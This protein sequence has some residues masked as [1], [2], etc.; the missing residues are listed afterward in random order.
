VT[1]YD[2]EQ[3]DAKLQD[4]YSGDVPVLEFDGG[5]AGRGIQT[6]KLHRMNRGL[7]TALVGVVVLAMLSGMWVWHSQQTNGHSSKNL[8]DGIQ[9]S[10]ISYDMDAVDLAPAVADFGVGL[11]R[12]S[13]RSNQ[14]C[15][16]SPLSAEMALAMTANGAGGQTLEQMMK[17]LA[18]GGDLDQLNTFL[19][20]YV[21]SLP[22]EPSSKFHMANSIWLNDSQ[23]VQVV[24]SFLQANADWFGAGVFSAPFSAQTV[25]DMNDWVAKQTDDMIKDLVKS[26]DPKSDAVVLLNALAFDAKWQQPY[27]DHN[28]TQ[29][30]FTTEDGVGQSAQFLN[31]MEST[32][33]DDGKAT[34]FVK[35]YDGD[36]YRFVALLPNEGVSMP[37]YLASLNWTETMQSAT[38]DSVWAI[39][40]EFSF[41]FSVDMNDALQ[42]MGMTD[43]FTSS[44]DFGQMGTMNGQPLYIGLV[45]Q[46]THIDVTP[47]GTTAGAA[48]EVV[49]MGGSAMVESKIVK[50][51]RPFV[52]AIVDSATELPIFIGVVNSLNG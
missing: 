44:A 5:E 25:R 6:A 28:I 29:D 42:A 38:S 8:M 1:K 23:D 2:D 50:L 20:R 10:H 33:L 24:P 9:T 11:L 16:V 31:S 13:L 39:L 12:Q 3:L 36:G 32:Y 41:D 34:G 7:V 26:L 40:P 27:Y 19:N 30:T 48:T 45:K 15:L 52:F 4:F 49:M 18:G 46:K 47:L 21:S 37:D 17:V 22:N 35:S 51:D 43:A 14:N